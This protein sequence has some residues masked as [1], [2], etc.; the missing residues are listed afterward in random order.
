[1]NLE[2]ERRLKFD[3]RLRSRRGWVTEDE[4]RSYEESLPDA[5]DK[6]VEEEEPQARPETGAE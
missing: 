6:I 4:V 1:M 2:D 3:R 5:S